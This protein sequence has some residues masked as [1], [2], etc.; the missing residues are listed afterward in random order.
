MHIPSVISGDV[1]V[2]NCGI[3]LVGFSFLHRSFPVP[4][5]KHDRI[6]ETPKVTSLPFKTAGVLLGPGC[7][8]A[9][10][11]VTAIAAYV[12]FHNSLPDDAAIADMFKNSGI[13]LEDN[14]N[15][16]DI[17]DML[18][19]DVIKKN[20]LSNYISTNYV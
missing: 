12:L 2:K 5:S 3:A 11:P 4:A 20:N 13:V 16:I 19:R 14:K 7:A 9:E 10:G 17:T 18:F 15:F 1:P 8:D 6:P